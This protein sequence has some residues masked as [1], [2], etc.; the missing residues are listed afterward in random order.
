MKVARSIWWVAGSLVVV[1]VGGFGPWATLFGRTVNGPD[2]E[3]VFIAAIMAGLALIVFAVSRN[4]AAAAVPL[5][6]GLISS[7]LIGQ[8]LVDPAGLSGSHLTSAKVHPAWG[9][10]VAL[11][12]SASVVLASA[13]VFV[14]TEGTLA[15]DRLRRLSAAVRPQARAESRSGARAERGGKRTPRR[16]PRRLERP[17]SVPAAQPGSIPGVRERRKRF[18]RDAQ[19]FVP[20]VVAERD[21]LLFTLPTNDPTL[22]SLFVKSEKDKERTVVVRALERLEAAGIRVPRATFVDIGANVGTAVFAALQAGFSSV[23]AFEPVPSTFLLLRA[24]LLLNGAE[25]AVRPIEIALSN[26]TGKATVD[27]KRGSR[28]ARVLARP[29]EVPRGH[30]QEVRVARLDDFVAEGVFDPSEVGLMLMDVEGHEC[31]VL[32][33]GTAVLQAN[34]PLVIELNPKLL[35]LSGKIDDLVD[36]LAQYYTHILDLR[37]GSNPPFDPVDR[38]GSMIER[39]EG[40]PTDILACRLPAA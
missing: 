39:L 15:T 32:E 40:R 28:R 33:G 36:L 30:S 12:G 22:G 5:L 6:A 1:L 35:R 38:V 21:G 19:D 20:Y 8:D 25:D 7:T 4:R 14:E 29:G 26:R 2:D 31:H 17:P 3:A 13:L 37:D 16:P 24:N 34:V 11:A 27:I 18:L 10:W 23:V 9:I